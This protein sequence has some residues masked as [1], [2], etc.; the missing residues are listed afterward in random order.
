MLPARAVLSWAM[1]PSMAPDTDLDRTSRTNQKASPYCF[2]LQ[3]ASTCKLT[4]LS[5]VFLLLPTCTVNE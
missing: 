4:T 2:A 1:A 3:Y 5:R